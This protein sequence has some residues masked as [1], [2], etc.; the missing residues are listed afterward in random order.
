MREWFL[1][2][3]CRQW[4]IAVT[5]LWPRPKGKLIS[6][7]ESKEDLIACLLTSCHIPWYG[8]IFWY[9]NVSGVLSIVL[10]GK[11]C[12]SLKA[13]S[14]TYSALPAAGGLMAA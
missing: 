11:R 13:F 10:L 6:D 14:A 9:L 2:E 1:S 5:Q 12:L 7:F 8:L 3:L 4:Q